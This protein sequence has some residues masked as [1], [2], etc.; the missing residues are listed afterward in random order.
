M[1]GANFICVHA[2]AT[3]GA[4]EILA[5]VN[6]G[7][8]IIR[9]A[10]IPG[11]PSVAVATIELPPAVQVRH[12]ISVVIDW[13]GFGAQVVPATG[14]LINR[15]P[16]VVTPRGIRLVPLIDGDGHGVGWGRA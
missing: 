15:E 16:V 8:R 1:S 3:I 12:E 9:V 2:G 5:A 6:R 14:E 13:D 7:V 10:A 4:E 11:V